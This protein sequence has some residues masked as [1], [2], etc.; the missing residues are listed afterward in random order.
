M[1]GRHALFHLALSST[2]CIIFMQSWETAFSPAR[3]PGKMDFT[4][5]S[6]SVN[7]I[8]PNNSMNSLS[9]KKP[10]RREPT[11]PSQNLP[12]LKANVPRFLQDD[13]STISS[14]LLLR[15]SRKAMEDMVF[16]SSCKRRG[17]FAF[18]VGKLWEGKVG[19]RLEG[20]FQDKELI[21]LLGETSLNSSW[22]SPSSFFRE[23]YARRGV[24]S[25][26]HGLYRCI[27]VVTTFG[28][29]FKQFR[30]KRTIDFSS[31]PT[32]ISSNQFCFSSGEISRN[33]FFP[34]NS[35]ALKTGVDVSQSQRS[36]LS[37]STAIDIVVS[38]FVDIDGEKE[39]EEEEDEEEGATPLPVSV[40]QGWQR[41]NGDGEAVGVT[42]VVV[43]L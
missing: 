10:S 12:T 41:S 17:T 43:E 9:W 34:S 38:V 16:W 31:L 39:E 6:T 11:F 33:G 30:N 3:N 23:M 18:N 24:Q 5:F 22:L 1:V 2:L 40:L 13:Q 32:L 26:V 14:I 19:S 20:F 35:L 28:S 15:A 27:A 36:S 4:I 7:D 21:E 29:F 8:S 42:L 37:S 25:L